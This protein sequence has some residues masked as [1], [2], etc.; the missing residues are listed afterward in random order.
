MEILVDS[1]KT[2]DIIATLC[3]AAC[4][5]GDLNIAK[6]SIIVIENVKIMEKPS[7]KIPIIKVE[8]EEVVKGESDE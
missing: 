6:T 5:T 3:S 8:D 7:D 1:Q 2:L 4:K